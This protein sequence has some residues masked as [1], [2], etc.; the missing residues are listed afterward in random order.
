MVGYIALFTGIFL[1]KWIDE[2]FPGRYS[3][4]L[5]L[6]LG[7]VLGVER[8]VLGKKVTGTEK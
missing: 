1:G 3:F 8:L 7:L 5:M 6:I 2:N 4:T